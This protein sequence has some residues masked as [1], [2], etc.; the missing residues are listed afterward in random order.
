MVNSLN[1]SRMFGSVSKVKSVVDYVMYGLIFGFIVMF[2]VFVV[3][4]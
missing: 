2:V 1:E 3:S 4:G